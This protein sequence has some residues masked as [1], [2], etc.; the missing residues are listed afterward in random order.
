MVYFQCE[1]ILLENSAMEHKVSTLEVQVSSLQGSQSEITKLKNEMVIQ[2]NQIKEKSLK[3]ERREEDLVAV[4]R[5][6]A[7]KENEWN[8]KED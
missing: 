7:A 5:A 4:S 8:L 1:Q 2:E 6:L 3:L